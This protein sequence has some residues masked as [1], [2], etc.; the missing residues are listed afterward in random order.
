MFELTIRQ[1][2]LNY[3][4]FSTE[5]I[6]FV[7]KLSETKWYTFVLAII[8][9]ISW[10]DIDGDLDQTP[11][12][13]IRTHYLISLQ[14]S[15]A[16]HEVPCPTMQCAWPDLSFP[17]WWMNL[18]TASLIISVLTVS[19]DITTIT[20]ASLHVTRPR[21][22]GVSLAISVADGTLKLRFRTWAF[23][24]WRMRSRSLP[25]SPAA[26]SQQ[27]ARVGLTVAQQEE[28]HRCH[29]RFNGSLS[30][31]FDFL[32]WKEPAEAHVTAACT[33]TR[34][35]ADPRAHRAWRADEH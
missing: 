1:I 14:Q 3:L 2:K 9:I 26:V 18:R 13:P 21:D 28:R 6:L 5:S 4:Q 29:E 10:H 34:V 33:F 30:W 19:G 23:Q 31:A 25:Q 20:G 27:W 8:I 11:N 22:S 15:S 7:I 12:Q 35:I 17:V 24:Q 16:P 32:S